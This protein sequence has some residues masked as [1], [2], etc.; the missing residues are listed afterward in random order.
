MISY[1]THMKFRDTVKNIYW[2]YF[3]FFIFTSFFVSPLPA[4]DTTNTSP[5]VK[6][7][8]PE[9]GVV[10]QAGKNV[11]FEGSAFDLED[12]RL[13]P[14]NMHWISDIDGYLGKGIC[15]HC[16]T[17]SPGSHIITLT[18]NDLQ[19]LESSDQIFITIKGKQMPKTVEKTQNENSKDLAQVQDKVVTGLSDTRHKSFDRNDGNDIENS[20]S[21][22]TITIGIYIAKETN[23]TEKTYNVKDIYRVTPL[24]CKESGI[25]FLVGI[26]L[27]TNK[28]ENQN[29]LNTLINISRQ[30]FDFIKALIVGSDVLLR[31]DMTEDELISY[32][33]QVK[34]STTLPVTTGQMWL[35][36]LKYSRVVQEVDFL[37]VH[38]HPY[39]EGVA[40][41]K[42]AEHVLKACKYIQAA[43]PEKK[44]IIGEITWPSTG[45]TIGEAVPSPQNQVKF[46]EDLKQLLTEEGFDYFYP[47]LSE[48]L[49]KKTL[50]GQNRPDSGIYNLDGLSE[51]TF[52]TFS[53]TIG[54]KAPITELKN[55]LDIPFERQVNM[56]LQILGKVGT[57][58]IIIE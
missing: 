48:H 1:K 4:Q 20:P 31:R 19:H 17:L 11:H 37:L 15:I 33:R 36:W 18:V 40:V 23:S 2:S 47:E 55:I 9:N 3:G 41:E 57:M 24:L 42:A 12:G 30:K 56:I 29:E 16:D 54:L 52:N 28:T 14:N 34:Q 7:L 10:L 22:N 50:E 32:I 43:F 38:V 35:L 27:G 51:Y 21:T 53:L 39:W 25:E 46:Y 5:A 58:F 44:I 45:K 13:S 26:M 8:K 49:T 6:I